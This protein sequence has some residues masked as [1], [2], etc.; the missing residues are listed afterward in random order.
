M[1]RALKVGRARAP[2]RARFKNA[3]APRAEIKK[4]A[5]NFGRA[6][7]A[8]R[9]RSM[10]ECSWLKSKKSKTITNLFEKLRN[11]SCCMQNLRTPLQKLL[12]FVAFAFGLLL[13]RTSQT[14]AGWRKCI[15]PIVQKWKLQT[16]VCEWKDL[17]CWDLREDWTRRVRMLSVKSENEK[18]ILRR[19]IT[20][21][22]Q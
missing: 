15:F 7:A 16:Q 9:A 19:E 12:S 1:W 6:R 14:S 2:A 20:S 5:S 18:W 10:N 21:Q 17:Q 13:L 8:R 4:R 3:R 11:F 22:L